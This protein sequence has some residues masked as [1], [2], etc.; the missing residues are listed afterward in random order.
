MSD[1]ASAVE[2]WE[3][4][5]KGLEVSVKALSANVKMLQESRSND[6]MAKSWDA[7]EAT[8]LAMVSA[9]D[10]EQRKFGFVVDYQRQTK[11][12]FEGAGPRPNGK[13]SPAAP[14]GHEQLKLIGAPSNAAVVEASLPDA[15]DGGAGGAPGGD[16]P[17][18]P[19]GDEDVDKIVDE[20]DED[21]EN[22][23][24]AGSPHERPED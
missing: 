16:K 15:P 8:R 21:E 9:Q 23:G 24:K 13:D 7:V 3:N 12:D 14:A 22:E 19:D 2:A 20:D 17:K 10:E 1:V 5:V 11:L 4:A 18:P 6:M